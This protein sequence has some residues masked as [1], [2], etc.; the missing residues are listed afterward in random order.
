MTGKSMAVSIRK[1]LDLRY[2]LHLP[3]GYATAAAKIRSYPLIIFLHGAG[4][5][6]ED[7]EKVTIHGIPR[8]I[9]EGSDVLSEYE[10][11]LACP[12]CPQEYWWDTMVDLGFL[13]GF[14]EG[15]MKGLRVDTSRIYLTGLSMGGYGT[16]ALARRNPRA[17]AAIAP[18][19]GGTQADDGLA[20]IKDMPIWAF[21]G[22]KDDVVRL[23]GSADAVN[24]I[25]GLGGGDK[26]RLTVYPDADHDS[27]SMTYSHPRLYE[28]MFSQV[29]PSFSMGPASDQGQSA[30]KGD[31]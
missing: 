6:G 30:G 16:W 27:W 2:W 28:W 15:C 31:A 11:I 14:V 22:A 18:I 29:N 17:F 21:H 5:R 23:S 4:E 26:V 13:D 20:A 12:Q 7:L 8:L 19:C 10:F 1:E 9:K 3:K 24:K 25:Y